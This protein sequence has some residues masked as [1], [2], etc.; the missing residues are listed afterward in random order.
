METKTILKK[1]RAE[2]KSQMSSKQNNQNKQ[3]K[4]K[5]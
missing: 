5:K 3:W 2:T 4:H 1:D